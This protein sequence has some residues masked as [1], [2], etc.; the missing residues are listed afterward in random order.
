MLEIIHASKTFLEG[1]P[2]A[3]VALNNVN[4]SLTKGEFVTIIGSNGAGKST[5]FNAIGG[6][7][8]L[9]RGKILLQ[10]DDITYMAEH[11]RASMIGRL[12]Q[13]PVKGTAPDMT[14]EENLAL[15]YNRKSKNVLRIGVHHKDVQIFREKIAQ[16]NMGLEN[17]MKTKV[18]LLSG[19]QRQALSLLMATISTPR[20][21]LLDEHTAALDPASAE[22]IML[23]TKNI[24]SQESIT[25]MMITHNIQSALKTGS[26]TIMLD[27]GKII[28]DIS[29]QER[30]DMTVPRLME[31]F[32]QQSKNTLDNDR[33]L[34]VNN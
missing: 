9:D 21:L 23:I 28:L 19:G 25:T 26:R 4:L 12:F 11:K 8:W 20:L 14:I 30:A 27:R 3:H 6:T 33:M 31:L 18:G 7:F 17:R 32:S 13:D 34:F 29:G 2:N 5:L 22:K 15:A 24:V 1:T 10:G 16:L